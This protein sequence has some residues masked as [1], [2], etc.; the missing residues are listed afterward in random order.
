MYCDCNSSLHPFIDNPEY[1]YNIGNVP[2]SN[3]A[4]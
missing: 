1:T 2:A 4:V 3:T